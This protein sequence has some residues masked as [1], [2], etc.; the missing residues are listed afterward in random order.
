MQNPRGW[1]PARHLRN[2]GP[3]YNR[4]AGQRVFD[5]TDIPLLMRLRLVASANLQVTPISPE[6]AQE[7]AL[8]G[9]YGSRFAVFLE[10]MEEG[11]K[12]LGKPI[13]TTRWR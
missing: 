9:S 11:V 2:R 8:I 4:P 12:Y 13:W 1:S 10:Q 3:F 6:L 7:S 5:N